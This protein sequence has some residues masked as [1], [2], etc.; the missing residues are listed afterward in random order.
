MPKQSISKYR[1]AHKSHVR[2]C[3]RSMSC[4]R[5]APQV[6]FGSFYASQWMDELR[7]K[8]KEEFNLTD[9]ELDQQT[10]YLL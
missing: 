1:H 2:R 4:T 3:R 10:L 9:E 5:F 8:L 6:A 7:E